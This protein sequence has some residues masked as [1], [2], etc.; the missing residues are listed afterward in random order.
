TILIGLTLV[1]PVF[2]AT[3]FGPWVGLVTALPG[4]LIGDYFSKVIS[5]FSFPWYGYAGL[6]VLGFL[7]GLAFLRTRGRYNTR[8]SITTAIVTSFIGLVV[9]VLLLM[10]GDMIA[11]QFSWAYVFS[12]YLPSYLA[13]IAALILLPI[14]LI[15]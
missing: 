6:A 5:V 11:Y 14:L 1:V 12:L 7:S 2:F 8:G 9:F 10:I 13:S 4:A 3:Q 15:I